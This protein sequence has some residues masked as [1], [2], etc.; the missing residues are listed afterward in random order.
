MRKLR[1]CSMLTND[2]NETKAPEVDLT[3]YDCV[4]CG[5]PHF[6]DG[7]KQGCKKLCWI[8]TEE[9][10][11][12]ACKH[13]M[14]EV[15][16]GLDV[17]TTLWDH[18]LC[19]IQIAGDC[20]TYLIDALKVAATES[21]KELFRAGQ[22]IKLAHNSSFERRILKQYGCVLQSVVDTLTLSRKRSPAVKGHGLA[23]V[24]ERELNIVLDKTQQTSDWSV[25]PLTKEQLV[26]AALDAEVLLDIYERFLWK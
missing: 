20:T 18:R 11:D 4:F 16:V 23:A 9:R 19:L 3:I 6:A 10:L 8:D 12:A 1:L 25:R 26:Y 21:L 14:R 22:P 13:L 2:S 5:V 7:C 24:C 15:V 17:E